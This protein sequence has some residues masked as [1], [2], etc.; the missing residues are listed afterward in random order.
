MLRYGIPDFKMDKGLIDRRTRQMEGEG[1]K[2]HYNVNI[3]VD[4]AVTDLVARHDVVVLSGGAEKP[5]DLP[6]PGRDP[7]RRAFR[8]G[9][10]AAA[11]TAAS[12]TKR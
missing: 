11:R 12:A 8:H 2:F 5:R 10:P 4:V 7:A 6:I 3:G 1:V 9:F